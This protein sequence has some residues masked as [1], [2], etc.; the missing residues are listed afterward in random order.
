MVPVCHI[1][2]LQ[3]CCPTC[4]PA[5]RCRRGH[6][7]VCSTGA[8]AA[9][10][11]RAGEPATSYLKVIAALRGGY[12]YGLHQFGV[13]LARDIDNVESEPWQGHQVT[14]AIGGGGGGSPPK[15]K[16]AGEGAGA[17]DDIG[18]EVH[19]VE[20]DKGAVTLESIKMAFKTE[21][22][23]NNERIKKE[24]QQAVGGVQA[25]VASRIGTVETE[26]TKQLQTTLAM[27]SALTDKQAKHMEDLQGVREEQ[28]AME[29][30]LSAETRALGERVEAM[31]WKMKWGG[32]GST[33][34][35]T[36][37]E[38]DTIGAPKQPAL[39]L[40]GW[41]GDTPAAEVLQKAKDVVRQLQLDV[42]VDHM[43]VPGVRRGFTLIP[44]QGAHHDETGE[45]YRQRIQ[46][47]ITKVRQAK[48]QLGRRRRRGALLVP[49]HESAT[50]EETSSPLG[51]KSEEVHSGAWGAQASD[52]GRI[53][54]GYCLV[55]GGQDLLS[56]HAGATGG[57]LRRTW[58]GRH[59]GHGRGAGPRAPGDPGALEGL[60][61]SLS[62]AGAKVAKSFTTRGHPR[63]H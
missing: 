17:A 42:D 3:V 32:G 25:E 29:T 37:A 19:V 15:R 1:P 28:A 27:L 2:H 39:I 52:R 24:I 46:N 48:V 50:R 45:G 33:N 43:F 44:L 7:K 36:T 5:D 16:A 51:S 49:R 4:P 40:G 56:G 58:M 38:V 57:G 23:C 6:R 63:R 41:E 31:E 8:T 20:G 61:T 54:H 55:P 62:D 10:L 22:S 35:T 21:L 9:G 14:G 47:A 34:S 26:V 18:D 59:Q 53:R 11:G 30:R 60:K 12:Q 13:Y